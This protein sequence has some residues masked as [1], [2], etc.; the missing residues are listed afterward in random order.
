MEWTDSSL[1][2]VWI[3]KLPV[4]KYRFFMWLHLSNY[5]GVGLVG[6]KEGN[7]T[8]Q[9][10]AMLRNKLDVVLHQASLQQQITF[11]DRVSKH[12]WTYFLWFKMLEHL[13]QYEIFS[14]YFILLIFSLWSYLCK[15][16]VILNLSSSWVYTLRFHWFS[17]AT[18]KVF[19]NLEYEV[20]SWTKSKHSPRF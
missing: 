3:T 19:S 5:L 12:F 9:E 18:F 14:A 13:L 20:S 6:C 16:L 4:F 2:Q 10:I 8:S 7:V 11:S 17:T 15:V 1:D